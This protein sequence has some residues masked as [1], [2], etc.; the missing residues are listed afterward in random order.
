MPLRLIVEVVFL[1]VCAVLALRPR[2]PGDE[3]CRRWWISAAQIARRRGLVCI[4]AAVLVLLVRA[5]VL[6][7]WPVP[8]P[9]IYD[10][11]S[12]LLQADT[13]AHARLANPAHPMWEFFESIYVLQ[14]PTYASK[15][16]PGQA[17]AMAAGQVLFGKPWF[18]ILLSCGALA[19]ALCWAL[20]GWMPPRWALLGSLIGLHVCIFSY[21]MNSHWGGAVAGIGGALVIGAYARLVRRKWTAIAWLYGAGAVILL[22]TRPYEGF[23]LVAPASLA[24]WL[25]TK[26]RRV[27]VWIPIIAMGIAGFAFTAYYDYRVTGNPFRLPYQEYSAQYESVPPL[28]ILPVQPA[29]TF[30]HFDLELLDHVWLRETNQTARSWRVLSARAGELYQ[31]MSVLFGDPLWILV[32]AA[33]VPAWFLAKRTRLLVVSAGALAA[34]AMIEIVFYA[35][36]AA[37]FTAVLLILLVQSLR[38]LRAWATRNLPGGQAAGRFA[39]L[40]LCGS[41]LGGGLATEM[42]HVYLKNTP[43][44][45]QA[46][47]A[48]KGELENDLLQHN[49]GRHVIFVRYTDMHSPHE[50]WIYNLADIDAQPVIWAQDMGA[51]NSK[52]VKYYPG[53]TFWMF[54]PDDNPGLLQSYGNP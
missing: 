8:R 22:L 12:Y 7:I 50:E 38:Y 1:A 15:Y 44:R 47:N 13:F 49:P 10:E 5:A 40:A 34:G 2:I 46:V 45:L 37:P 51:E 9:S 29:K 6:P 26:Q 39:I 20:Q 43:D 17:M 18:G 31:T 14:Q 11:F 36:Y 54:K 3:I 32:L 19:A 42:Y 41:L 25:K 4:S 33:F 35:H 21:W 30:R 28:T 24:L 16:P 52:L 23:L 48:R 53:R 27:A